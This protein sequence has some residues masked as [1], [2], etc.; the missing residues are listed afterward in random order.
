MAKYRP[1]EERF[2][3]KYFVDSNGCWIWTASTN[4][5]GYGEIRFY[6]TG[7]GGNANEYAHRVSWIL[8]NGPIPEGANILHKCDIGRCVNPDHLFL[9][10][11]SDNSVDCLKKNRKQGRTKLSTEDVIEIRKHCNVGTISK[12]NEGWVKPLTDKYGISRNQLWNIA[13][14]YSW[15]FV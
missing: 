14:G 4:N 5:A 6:K 15:R 3:E 1:I 7:R 8:K 10:S 9:G 12:H 2:R 13:K 11:L